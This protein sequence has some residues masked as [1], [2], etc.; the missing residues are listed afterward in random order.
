MNSW[1]VSDIIHGIKGISHGVTHYLEKGS[2]LNASRAALR[3]GRM[4]GLPTDMMA[5]L[6]ADEVKNV[7]EIID[8]TKE[9]LSKLNGPVA[10]LKVMHII[11][12]R[13]SRP[14]EVA[15]ATMWMVNSYGHLYAEDVM[16]GQG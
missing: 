13:S 5:Q 15:A 9:K 11:H 7:Q 10:R 12:N 4:V 1:S 8:Q 14:E 16:T 2:K 3:M 6:Q